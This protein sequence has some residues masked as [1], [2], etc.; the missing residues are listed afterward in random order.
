M[1]TTLA[2]NISINAGVN[3]EFG[4]GVSLSTTCDTSILFTAHSTFT[5]SSGTAGE[6]YFSGF[7]LSDIDVN[8]CS[9][10]TF[11]LKA[12][13]SGTA[14]A[15]TLFGASDSVV[16]NDS[17][18]VLYLAEGQNGVSMADTGTIGTATITF[19]SPLALA[20]SV[21]KIT[22]ES[23]GMTTS[24]QTNSA[25]AVA[26]NFST[27]SSFALYPD[28]Y[29]S[30]LGSR[31]YAVG[32]GSNV[33]VSSDTGTSWAVTTL[34]TANA[35]TVAASQDG[36]K[37]WVAGANGRIYFSSNSGSSFVSKY[38]Y[39][40]SS[41]FEYISTDNTGTKLVAARC[42]TAPVTL[43]IT[44][45]SGSTWET[46]PAPVSNGC[47]YYGVA[48]SGNGNNI[49]AARYNDYIYKTSDTGIT[50]AQLTGAGSRYWKGFA[51]STDG[52]YVVAAAHNDYAYY[53]TNGGSTWARANGPI[54]SYWQ[55]ATIDPSGR[56]MAV[57]SA[58]GDIYVSTNYGST[59]SEIS[60]G[61]SLQYWY[62]SAISSDGKYLF[63]GTYSYGAGSYIYKVLVPSGL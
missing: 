16:I 3:V 8:A 30:T 38:N 53:S 23:T 31:I 36:S 52:N 63:L 49:F 7:R 59:W 60:L 42:T 29:A 17:A 6:F 50:W 14:S 5:N 57:A 27:V 40:G 2:A 37:V 58:N 62:S 47:A 11:T 25:S 44:N 18:T 1:S 15:L 22:L 28:I 24:S 46:F 35:M 39:D 20:T 21:K 4:Q 55:T 9:G 32:D 51:V 19:A 34:P 56:I 43:L 33:Y 13:D 54:S 41:S 61:I 26:Y 48:M 12:Y 45:N 10:A